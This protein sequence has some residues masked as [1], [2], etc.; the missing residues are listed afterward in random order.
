MAHFSALYALDTMDRA[1][2]RPVAGAVPVSYGLLA[3]FPSR[4]ETQ[5]TWVADIVL[6][7]KIGGLLGGFKANQALLDEYHLRRSE[8]LMYSEGTAFK[9]GPDTKRQS[10]ASATSEKEQEKIR[11]MTK[12]APCSCCPSLPWFVTRPLI[13]P[14]CAAASD[15]RGKCAA[16]QDQRP[17]RGFRASHACLRQRGGRT[18]SGRASGAHEKHV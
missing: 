9:H 13:R 6:F 11:K 17:L 18:G 12:G 8:A 2:R 4:D 10:L 16:A 5:G 14:S 3:P 7:R 1:G 15:D